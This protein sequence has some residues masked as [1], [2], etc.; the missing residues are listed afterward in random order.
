MLNTI[1]NNWHYIF[2]TSNKIASL[3]FSIWGFITLVTPTDETLNFIENTFVRVLVAILIL[4][5]IY[6]IIFLAV[7]AYS[8]RQKSIKVF[9]LHSNHSLYV[10][11]G[12]LFNRDNHNERINIAFAGNRCFDTIVDD[13][14]LGSSKI[15][16]I[17]LNRI[18]ERGERTQER[19][20][21][22]IQNNL[23]LHGYI[24]DK[25]SRKEKRSGNLKRYEVGAVAEICGIN[26]EQYFILGL[27]SF[28][29]EL[30]AYVEKDEYIKAISSLIKYI[31]DR[32]QGFPTYMP[33]IGTGGAD[34]GSIN[35]LIR[36]II[37][38]VELYKDEIDCD[39]H[40][41]VGNKEEK[42]GLLSLK[43]L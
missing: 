37:K 30:R 31:S 18:Y 11:Y 16:G 28:D 39:I 13:D 42:L 6:V 17:A 20:N 12:D 9:D 14:L 35:V 10:E 22:E 4:I 29:R 1:K 21:E 25:L 27:T 2:A 3:V 36:F 5:S 34:V 38:T 32:S 26:N 19:V 40:I 33:V 23:S 41:V 43:M 8:K 15:H 24:S 7:S